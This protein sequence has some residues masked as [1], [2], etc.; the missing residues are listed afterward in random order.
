V[1]YLDTYTNDKAH[2]KFNK[3]NQTEL[4]KNIFN[5]DHLP[6]RYDNAIRQYV[7]GLQGAAARTRLAESAQAVLQAIVEK[8]EVEGGSGSMESAEAR[9]NAY[10]AALKSQIERYERANAGRSEY[11]EEQLESMRQDAELG[12]RAENLFE[13]LQHELRPHQHAVASQTSSE[14]ARSASTPTSHTNGTSQSFDTNSS[15]SKPST[16][17][18]RKSRKSRT[19]GSSTDD[20]SSED[21]KP[22]SKKPT[23][24]PTTVSEALRPSAIP[25]MS[26][27]ISQ[28]L[29][30]LASGKRVIFDDDMLDSMFPKKTYLDAGAKR[31]DEGGRGSKAEESESSSDSDSD[32]DE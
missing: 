18:K 12:K 30:K 23:T 1:K 14:T 4:L 6:T 31:K 2:W 17:S 20:S 9:R 11:D 22:T 8:E 24:G 27:R 21:E 26:M 19:Q 32:S 15:T 28:P 13:L 10:A 25:E 16:T 3:N 29:E 7:E 5:L